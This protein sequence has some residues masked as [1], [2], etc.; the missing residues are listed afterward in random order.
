MENSIPDTA[1]LEKRA[2]AFL[3]R[4]PG[5]PLCEGCLAHELESRNP[6]LMRA[7][8][9]SLLEHDS[10]R[11]F[12]MEGT[13]SRCFRPMTVLYASVVEQDPRYEDP[14]A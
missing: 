11:F 8:W 9:R 6:L 14:P 2:P 7:V 1:A 3:Q 13:C 10:R 5:L 12:Q 4:R